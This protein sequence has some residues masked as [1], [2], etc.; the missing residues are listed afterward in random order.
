MSIELLRA[1]D[2]AVDAVR[3]H[4]RLGSCP[5]LESRFEILRATVWSIAGP[6][7][8]AHVNRVL[9]AALPTWQ[10]LSAR[11]TAS[12][13]TL[14]AELRGALSML[15]DA[16]D[17]IG[18][19]GGYW[20]SA[21][22]RFV[23]LPD[24]A[25]YL[26]VGGAPSALLQLDRE[27]VQFHGP[28]RHLARR[29]AELEAALP[30]EDFDCWT[31]RPEKVSL[32]EWVREVFE[33]LERAPYTPSSADAFEFYLPAA[34][35]QGSSQF[36]RWFEGVENIT[37]TLLARRRRLYG[38]REY[39]LVDVRAG[40]IVGACELHDVDVRRLMYALD[41][42][43]KN[44]VRARPGRV[45]DRTEWLFTSELPRAEQRAFAAL[46]TLTIPDERRFERRWTFTR[47]EELALDML[48]SLGI[49]LGQHP[50]EDRR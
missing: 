21:V 27:A 23:M 1:A 20:A 28:H 6:T 42:E 40:R 39:R 4:L 22:T 31:K 24:S 5:P 13:E 10:L 25:G 2:Q 12:E 8:K 19:S 29:P 49:A 41:L 35:R 32:Q 18:L 11:T 14:R 48:R 16:G 37:G 43:A 9:G 36:F 7:S 15:E 50:R 30:L 17:L 46:G 34:S 3:R 45:G 26:L 33:S 38:A 47:N 44:P